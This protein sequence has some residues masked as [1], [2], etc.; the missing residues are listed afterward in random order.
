MASFLV[1]TVLSTHT[2]LPTFIFCGIAGLPSFVCLFFFLDNQLN[3]ILL[4]TKAAIV[5]WLLLLGKKWATTL[6]TMSVKTCL[7]KSSYAAYPGNGI[8]TYR[9][10]TGLSCWHSRA[11]YQGPEE[12]ETS[13]LSLQCYNHPII[14][15]PEGLKASFFSHLNLSHQLK[16]IN[17]WIW[18]LRSTFCFLNSFKDSHSSPTF[19]FQSLVLYLS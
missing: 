15:S 10:C 4:F 11:I 8:T 14:S 7:W 12:H 6:E 1:I 19:L 13:L 18:I 16:M 9:T 2:F 5:F 17:P 3:Y